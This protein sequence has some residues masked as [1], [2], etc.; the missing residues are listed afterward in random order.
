MLGDHG[1]IAPLEKTDDA[2]K[3]IL[4]TLG[5]L[6][7]LKDVPSRRRV[8]DKALSDIDLNSR[9]WHEA[10]ASHLASQ[11]GIEAIPAHLA[12]L[13]ASWKL[14][15]SDVAQIIQSVN[16]AQPDEFMKAATRSIVSAV[17]E[18][19][20][21]M[22]S[23]KINSDEIF[24][25]IALTHLFRRDPE[26]TFAMFVIDGVVKQLPKALKL[27]VTRFTKL[28]IER[29]DSSPVPEWAWGYAVVLR[30]TSS[31]SGYFLPQPTEAYRS[32]LKMMRSKMEGMMGH[33]SDDQFHQ[34]IIAAAISGHLFKGDMANFSGLASAALEQMGERFAIFYAREDDGGTTTQIHFI[35][36]KTPDEARRVVSKLPNILMHDD[37]RSLTEFLAQQQDLDETSKD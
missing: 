10:I 23:G 11:D 33:M 26:S 37:F 24:L 18:F 16:S 22:Q 30:D 1:G 14:C 6:K 9:Y 8:I 2:A 36:A 27:D 25:R 32:H 19:A 29:Y 15:E 7:V 34:H 12:A 17:P 31:R 13:S 20:K 28:C 4:R 35:P 5:R 3:E 21:R